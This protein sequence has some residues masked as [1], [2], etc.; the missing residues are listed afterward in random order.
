MDA[1]PLVLAQVASPPGA[2]L[3]FSWG[4]GNELF[5]CDVS[6]QAHQESTQSCVQW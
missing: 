1:E 5:C 3:H 4:C 2:R 6:G